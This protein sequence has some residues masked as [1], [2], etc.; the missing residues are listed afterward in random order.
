[1]TARVYPTIAAAVKAAKRTAVAPLAW[2][3]VDH[4]LSRFSFG[5]TTSSRSYVTKRGPDAWYDLMVSRARSYPGYSGH[6]AVAAQGPLLGMTPYDLRQWLKSNNREYGWDAMDQLTRV[7]LGLQAWSGS[8]L[9]EVL[10]DFFSNHLNV[11]NHN[12]DVWVTRHAY[13]RDVVRKYAT[14]SFTNML[15]ASS[16]HP[17]MLTYLSLKDST[18]GAVNEN[19]GRE[20]LELHTVG[21]R[22]SENDVKNA[23]RLLTGRTLTNSFHYVFDDY[24]HPT[25]KVTVLGFTHANSNAAAGEKAGDDLLRYLASH[26]YTAQNLARKMCVR[27]VSDSPSTDLVNA[28]AKAYLDGR[29][30]ILPMVST[31]LRSVE[32]WQSRGKK[33]RRPAE[34]LLATVRVLGIGAS[35]WKDALNTLTW[36]SGGMGHTPLEWAAPN[37]YP[38]VAAAW[39][40][41]GA[42]LKTWEQHVALTGGWWGGLTK[43]DVA[44]LY[45]DAKTSGEAIAAMA[46][47]LTGTTW[48]AD[49][50]AAVQTVAGEPAATAIGRS[51]LSWLGYYVAAVILDGPHH[52]LR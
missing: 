14:G 52:A 30:Q 45:G 49:H 10:V 18:K 35:S 21:L 9:A 17:A 4:L 3:P 39:R 33:V 41:P 22:Y 32:F 2:D 27:F 25:G 38:D 48:T 6:P 24:V 51:R 15:L 28:V 37:G 36:V 16:K 50:L 31:I 1:M 42:L 8:Q 11:P 43:P 12:G 46:K 19:Y 23:A 20:L 47:R 5:S 29:T 44:A 13:D 26:P 40:S 34:N 7:T